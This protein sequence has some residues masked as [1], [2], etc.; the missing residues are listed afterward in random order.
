MTTQPSNMLPPVP[1]RTSPAQAHPTAATSTASTLRALPGTDAAR[2]LKLAAADTSEPDRRH[3]DD[4]N[5]EAA[6]LPSGDEAAAATDTVGSA[7]ADT[8]GASSVTG[9]SS[10]AGTAAEATAGASFAPAGSSLFAGLTAN[11]ELTVGAI[12]GTVTL[13]AA[14]TGKS[15]Y[16]GSTEPAPAPAPLASGA[17]QQ[18]GSAVDSPATGNRG[19]ED[20]GSGTSAGS[21]SNTASGSGTAASTDA[22]AGVGAAAGS[23]SG[24]GAALGSHASSDAS[25]VGAAGTEGSSG[26]AGGSGAP[27]GAVGG[28]ATS[29]STGHGTNPAHT[30][31]LNYGTDENKAIGAAIFNGASPQDTPEFI[32]ITS[33]RGKNAGTVNGLMTLENGTEI[34]VG[35]VISRADFER[36]FWN[37][38]KSDG[39]F[40]FVPV[41]DA[42]G[43]AIPNTAEQ[44]V[45]IRTPESTK[46]GSTVDTPATENG[47]T[48][49]DTTSQTGSGTGT[50]TG[51]NAGTP[52]GTG[53]SH[54]SGADSGGHEGTGT[55][56]SGS[57]S[58][59]NAVSGSGSDSPTGSETPSGSN[60]PVASDTSTNPDSTSGSGNNEQ[61]PSQA[62]GEQGDGGD[63][64]TQN[65]DNRGTASQTPDQGGNDQSGHQTPNQRVGEQGGDGRTPPQGQDGPTNNG[66]TPVQN[67][68]D[69]SIGSEA[70]ARNGDAQSSD[71]ITPA[72]TP[73]SQGSGSQSPAQNASG[74]GDDSQTPPKNAGGGSDTGNP[75]T[76]NP[77]T[78]DTAQTGGTQTDGA[79]GED[80]EHGKNGEDSASPSNPPTTT[81]PPTPPDYAPNQSVQQAIHANNKPVGASI[82]NGTNP[83]HAPSFV[84]ITAVLN[85]DGGEVPDAMTLGKEGEAITTDQVISKEQFDNVFLD[86]LKAPGGSFKF[87]P[88]MDSEGT[89]MPGATEQTVSIEFNYVH[90][91]QSEPFRDAHEG[92]DRFSHYRIFSLTEHQ[93]T[94]GTLDGMFKLDGGE[95]TTL[96]LGDLIRPEDFDKLYWDY[97]SNNGGRFTLVGVDASGRELTDEKNQNLVLEDVAKTRTGKVPPE[98]PGGEETDVEDSEDSDDIAGHSAALHPE[99]FTDAASA[100]HG[101][102]HLSVNGQSMLDNLLEHQVIHGI[103]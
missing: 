20:T 82:F 67:Q 15:P 48:S 33:I 63:T 101:S 7:G 2:D 55:A 49:H 85:K 34:T 99:S 32:R 27:D 87:I 41:K 77:G 25:H 53:A 13:G 79:K 39:C 84:K 23:S 29:P 68:G 70:P 9:G 46:P 35:Q 73:G 88:V 42:Q 81:P 21:A 69:Q 86:A 78:S 40:S 3:E 37:A 93:D 17:G 47:N 11:P 12:L 5:D 65:A 58:D 83:A 76:G 8:A 98:E 52:S 62:T 31:S 54:G 100:F 4:D 10:A 43:T 72:P 92:E 71:G 38:S 19:S 45:I 16:D 59:S 64:P 24:A 50:A 66:Q 80:G 91:F 28:A 57:G 18:H 1:T 22:G 14:M 30:Q 44:T 26:N 56:G 61:S 75:A 95:R 6:W 90:H 60:P 94:N 102:S 74:Q 103:L 89:E 97:S 36:I 96:K 51:S